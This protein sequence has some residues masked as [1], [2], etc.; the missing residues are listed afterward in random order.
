[1]DIR[2]SDSL[3]FLDCHALIPLI[4]LWLPVHSLL[5]ILPLEFTFTLLELDLTLV[6]LGPHLQC[7]SLLF[8]FV[9]CLRQRFSVY[10]WLSLCNPG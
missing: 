5:L 1:M 6:L 2:G 9:V 10:T 3:S 4:L 8:L 7:S